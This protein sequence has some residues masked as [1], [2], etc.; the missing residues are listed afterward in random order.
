MK[1][2][3]TPRLMQAT[4]AAHYLG[5]SPSKLRSMNLPRKEMGGNMVYERAD[6]DAVADA[7]PYEG[8][9]GGNKCDELFGVQR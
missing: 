8:Q 6:L 1:P 4:A 3:F 5:V 7:L 2:T 9:T